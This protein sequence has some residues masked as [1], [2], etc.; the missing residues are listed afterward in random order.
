M[1]SF[2]IFTRSSSAIGIG[3]EVTMPNRNFSYFPV[4][5]LAS[6]C[7][8]FMFPIQEKKKQKKL[9]CQL[10]F[11]W[12]RL[13]WHFHSNCWAVRKRK[14][15]KFRFVPSHFIGWF[16][17]FCQCAHHKMSCFIVE[18]QQTKKL[19]LE[20]RVPSEYT[21]NL[22]GY[23]QRQRQKSRHTHTWACTENI[24]II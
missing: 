20:E 24:K 14:S 7:I 3:M 19:W 13:K 10:A 1:Q 6:L 4:L 23:R 15:R 8:P 22:D 18:C 21:Q 11:G 5:Y 2:T 16:I 12:S 17:A 9:Y